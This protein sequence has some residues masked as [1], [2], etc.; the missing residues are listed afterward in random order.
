MN[1]ECPLQRSVIL[2]CSIAEHSYYTDNVNSCHRLH[3]PAFLNIPLQQ[4]NDSYLH[5][6]IITVSPLQ[7]H[8]NS[9]TL[10]TTSQLGETSYRMAKRGFFVK[11]FSSSSVGY[12]IIIV[13]NVPCNGNVLHRYLSL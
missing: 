6:F 1:K 3:Q 4:G 13:S 2:Y 12:L 5:Y 7:Q 11:L 9:L 10:V 8:D